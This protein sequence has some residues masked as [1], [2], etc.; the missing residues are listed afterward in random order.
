MKINDTILFDVINNQ[1]LIKQLS[2]RYYTGFCTK[3]SKIL[4]SH[5]L[6]KN[7]MKY[8]HITDSTQKRIKNVPCENITGSKLS[9]LTHDKG[10]VYFNNGLHFLYLIRKNG[11]YILTSKLK[12]KNKVNDKSFYVSQM[13]DGFLYFDF[14]SDSFSCFINNP[15]DILQNKSNELIKEKSSLDIIKKITKEL[16]FGNSTTKLKYE[17]DYQVKWENTKLCLQAFLFIK[18]AKVINT[19]KISQENT[20]LSFS[21][22]LKKKEQSF[23][24]VIEVD[25]FYDESMKVINPFSVT[26]HFRNQPHGKDRSEIKTIYIDSFM[27]TGYERIATKLKIQK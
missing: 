19:T 14:L 20:K 25:T 17:Q 12:Y 13:M 23:I 2:E 27:K 3:H 24:D 1:K 26:G 15:L 11:V 16:E 5:F 7:D 9:G 6:N 21:D 22:R 18:F 8:F 4:M 10:L